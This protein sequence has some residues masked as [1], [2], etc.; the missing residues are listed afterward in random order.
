LELALLPDGIAYQNKDVLLKVLSDSY[1]DK[2]FSALGI[3]LPRIKQVL[4][5]NLPQV[6]AK[7]LRAD[8][9]FLLE[10]D[11]ILIVDY[12]SVIRLENFLKYME[13]ILAVLKSF[14]KSDGKVYNIVVLV[15][16]TGDIKEAPDSFALD[17]LQIS[18]MQVF[19]SNFDTNGLYADLKRK[20]E[21]GERL[22]DEDVMR[23]IVL[24]LTEPVAGKKQELVEKTISLA[25]EVADE[26]QQVFIV[27]GILVAADKFIDK[28]YSKMVRGWIAMTKVGRIFEEEKIEYANKLLS[29]NARLLAKE[30]LMDNEDVIKIMKYSKLPKDEILRI[31]HEL[32][33][34]VG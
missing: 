10:D 30:M 4:P 19:L 8:N 18:I 26:A 24:P 15:I 31:Q 28:D 1:K 16:Y 29:D 12:E 22:T 9:I 23:F 13:Y 21:A 6:A 20:V 32:G 11:R 7:E 25:R 33:I 34:A 3:D 17:S 5:T 27:A 14:F 2:S